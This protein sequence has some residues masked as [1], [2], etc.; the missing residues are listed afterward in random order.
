VKVSVLNS[1][2]G[3]SEGLSVVAFDNRE[4]E[5]LDKNVPTAAANG[6]ELPV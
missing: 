1:G 6:L 4:D 3:L 5:S 2:T